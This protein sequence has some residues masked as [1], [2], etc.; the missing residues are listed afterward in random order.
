MS[1]KFDPAILS[2]LEDMSKWPG[3]TG[4]QCLVFLTALDASFV[5]AV[6]IV[7]TVLQV[8]KPVSVQLQG[9]C[10]D[11][12]R[13]SHSIED[14]I[15]VLQPHRNGETFDGIFSRSTKINGGEIAMPR[16][17][18]RQSNRSNVPADCANDYYKRAVFLP[19][20]DTCLV[21]LQQRFKSHA[22]I[23]YRLSCLLPALCDA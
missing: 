6:E 10:Q 14:C 17:T 19:F 1:R 7:Y 18:K 12:Y 23:A 13:A 20:V 15:T 5:I 4:S 2:S 22:L 9:K 16:V 8:I 21:Q 11:I 3:D